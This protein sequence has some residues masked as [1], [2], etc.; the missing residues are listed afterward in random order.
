MLY[1]V[2]TIVEMASI[3]IRVFLQRLKYTVISPLRYEV[4]KP[5]PPP[6][7]TASA[8]GYVLLPQAPLAEPENYNDM[9]MER[10]VKVS[11]I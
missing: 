6:R 7:Y 8:P 9:Y 3:R 4:I 11:N 2:G 10:V 1:I 5:S